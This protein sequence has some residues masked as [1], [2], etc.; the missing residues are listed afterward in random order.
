MTV[1]ETDDEAA[2]LWIDKAGVRPERIQR[3]GDEDNFWAMGDA[4]P[5]GPH[6][7]IFFDKGG[8]RARRRRPKSSDTTPQLAR[9]RR[10]ADPDR[11]ASGGRPGLGAIPSAVGSGTVLPA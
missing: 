5:S 3:M 1:H 10:W 7:E 4:G 6:S 8:V 2:Q 9:E 11:G